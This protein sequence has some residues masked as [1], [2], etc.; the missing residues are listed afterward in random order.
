MIEAV[1]A[2]PRGKVLAYGQ[3]AARA[4]KPR[5]ARAVA[6]VLR[7]EGD[8]PWWRVVRADGTLAG[9]VAAEQEKRLR[10]EGVQVKDGKLLAGRP[11]AR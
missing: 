3:V 2:I 11:R 1:R 4:G 8:L 9:A 5:A 7:H 6:R 10:A